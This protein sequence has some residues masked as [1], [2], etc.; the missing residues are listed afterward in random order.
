[1]RSAFSAIAQWAAAALAL[2]I[3]PFYSIRTWAA[4]VDPDI[5]WHIRTGD[6]IL[7]HHAVPRYAIFSQH[8]E[9]PWIAYSWLFDVIVS[10]VE[11]RFGL[12]GIPGFLICLQVF[13]SLTFLIAIRH[14]ARSFWWSWLI[15]S[16]AI[17]AFYVNPLRSLLFTLLFF[18]LELVLIFEAERRAEDKLLFWTA[19]L[20]FLWANFH[21]Q[22]IHGLFVLALYVGTRII[23][24]AARKWLPGDSPK[25]SPT[26]LLAVLAAALACSCLGPN[27][28]YPYKVAVGYAVHTAQFQFNQE[29][30]AMSFRRPE[31]FVE[32]FLLIAACYVVGRSRGRDLF[33]PLLLLVTAL[34][35]FHSL[36]DAWFVSIAAAFVLAEAVGQAQSEATPDLA[37]Q[38]R[39][40][41]VTNL[42]Y[43]L[44]A[45]AAV[46]L[47]FGLAARQ[48]ISAP[49]LMAV[50]DQIYPIRAAEFVRDSRLSGPMYN[51]Y[52]WGGFLIFNLREQPVSIDPRVD[53][54]GDELATDSVNTVNAIRWKD[55]PE[56]T[57]ANFVLLERSAPLTSALESDPR[58]RLAYKDHLAVVFVR[59]QGR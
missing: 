12:A 31:H 6:W 30:L 42:N 26:R 5:W 11:H 34:V 24:V 7:A 29:M 38:R 43:A 39:I 16:L 52:N 10:G 45:I 15:A 36:R 21:I 27:W 25:T 57:R 19:P 53:A 56:L 41:L 59:E 14:F 32:L 46:S 44:A 4:V 55:D 8:L 40:R 33:R 1:M 9:R 54:Y 51:S 23:A 49:T 47:S 13:I 50:I 37:G 48:G 18:T 17:Y 28:A 20:F 58:Y 3:A 35:S 2:V 22:F